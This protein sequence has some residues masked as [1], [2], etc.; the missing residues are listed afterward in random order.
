MIRLQDVPRPAELT[1]ELIEKLTKEFEETGRH[2][3]KQNFITN[4]LLKMSNG[5]CAFSECM[6]VEE[7]KYLEVEHFHPK[8]LYPSEVVKWENLLPISSPCNKTKGDHD[9][10]KE[11]ILNPRYQNPQEHLYFRAYEL[12][13]KTSQGDLTINKLKLNDRRIWLTKRF[14]IGEL[15]KSKLKDVRRFLEHFISDN[16]RSIFSQDEIMCKLINL[17]HEGTPKAE[18]SAVVA[19]YLL[20]DDDFQIIKDLMRKNNLWDEE[21]ESL[22]KQLKF[23]ALNVREPKS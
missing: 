1:D 5:K 22:E 6:L 4:N 21:F 19:S 12:K 17:L 8:K 7:G 13:P 23:C 9:T 15:A 14:E 2:V 18:Y 3:W 11:P 10:K 20:N 16:E